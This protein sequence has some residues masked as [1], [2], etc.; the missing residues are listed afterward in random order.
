MAPPRTPRTVPASRYE[1]EERVGN[2]RVLLVAAAIALLVAVPVGVSV[3]MS[4]VDLPWSDA[5][6]K[7]TPEWVAVPQLRATTIDGAVVKA[8]VALD[9]ESAAARSAIQRSI[10]Q[11]GLVLEISVAS[12]SEEQVRAPGGI[13][14]L[15]DDM[16]KRLNRYLEAEGS[17]V[18]KAVAIQDLIVNPQ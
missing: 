11:V 10:Q 18:V 16:R 14:M 12:R 3:G 1:E 5:P 13:A 4:W 7:S 6:A 9:V 2:R 8:R 17:D 15:S